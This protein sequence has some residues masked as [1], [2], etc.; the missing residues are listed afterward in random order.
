MKE[1]KYLQELLH[2]TESPVATTY[3]KGKSVNSIKQVY[4][5]LLNIK[6]ERNKC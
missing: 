4:T 6:V 3:E 5:K 1:K 2:L